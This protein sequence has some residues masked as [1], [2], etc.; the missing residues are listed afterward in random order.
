MKQNSAATGIDSGIP[1]KQ[2]GI[3]AKMFILTAGAKRKE[4]FR[5]STVEKG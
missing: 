1:G 2:V 5:S 4:G 3:L